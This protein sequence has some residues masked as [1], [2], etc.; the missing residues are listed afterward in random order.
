V[1]WNG[2]RGAPWKKFDLPEP[3]APTAVTF[4]IER[5]FA[6]DKMYNVTVPHA[7]AMHSPT[8]LMS[9]LNGSTIVWSL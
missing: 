5:G 2:G 4:R 8:T 7:A 6:L 1:S 3:F 9:R